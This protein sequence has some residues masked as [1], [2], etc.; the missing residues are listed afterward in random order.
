M[1]EQPGLIHGEDGPT[2]HVRIDD[3]RQPGDLEKL[4]G[5][6]NRSIHRHS[7]LS[8]DVAP[9]HPQPATIVD[10]QDI[11]VALA[12]DFTVAEDHHPTGEGCHQ[13]ERIELDQW[14]PAFVDEF[15][16]SGLGVADIFKIFIEAQRSAILFDPGHL[17]QIFTN[18]CT[19]ACVHGN[20]DK[21]IEIRVYSDALDSLCMEVAD[22][23]P[24]IE[25]DIR[26][27]IFEPFYTTSHQGSGLGLY[28]V[29]QLCDLNNA[30]ITTQTNQYNGTSFVLR[31]AAAA[32]DTD[33][34]IES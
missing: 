25:S 1:P 11:L 28:I 23:G 14:L 18:L 12:E 9:G 34:R 27:Q 31:L 24:G 15:C 17:N 26:E 32:I 7:Q 13:S 10:H 21:P 19:N 16:L 3:R 22:R 5:K 33:N 30:S 2:L 8:V 20:A 4:G 6:R 29:S